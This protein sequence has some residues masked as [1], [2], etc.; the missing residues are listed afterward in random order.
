MPFRDIVLAA[1]AAAALHAGASGRADA[2]DGV[3]IDDSFWSPKME[4][5]NDVT[6]PDVLRKF[7]GRHTAE[8][9]KHNAFANFDHVAAGERGTHTHF[10][11]PWFDGLIY[12]TIRGISDYLVM[13][14]DTALEARVDRYIDA[15]AA[16]QASEPSGYLA[17]YTMLKEPEHRWGENGGFLRWQ[18]D[19]YNAGMMVEAAVHYYRATGKTRLLEVAVKCA[20]NM[21]DVMGRR[22]R[23]MSCR[24]TP[25][26]KRRWSSSTVCSKTSPNSRNDSALTW[27][28]SVTSIWSHSG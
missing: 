4:V 25:G 19:V 11:E 24:R 3:R 17:T 28:S 12:E 22:R 8:P 20:S 5:W 13:Y 21:A 6:I 16:A 7:E 9:G 1:A 27:M 10:G 23:R 15:I 2:V 26:P 18:H 14:P